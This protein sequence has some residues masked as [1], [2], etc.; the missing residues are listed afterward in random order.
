MT[1]SVNIQTWYWVRYK[2]CSTGRRL[3]F[4]GRAQMT[5][6]YQNNIKMHCAAS[7]TVTLE[8]QKNGQYSV[9]NKTCLLENLTWFSYMDLL[10]QEN[11]IRTI[12][13]WGNTCLHQIPRHPHIPQCYGISGSTC[14]LTQ[15]ISS[16]IL[17]FS[18][19]NLNIDTVCNHTSF[20]RLSLP[21]KSKH[22]V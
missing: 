8:T 15:A 17:I 19:S 22:D 21:Y 4:A 2:A 9:S 11:F 7:A 3:L 18:T 1:A 5:W 20:M 12:W 14:W 13:E 6:N 16:Q 10:N